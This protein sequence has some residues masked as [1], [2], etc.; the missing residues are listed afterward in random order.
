LE[1]TA[2]NK[3]GLL[4]EKSLHRSLKQWYARK[5]D[6]LEVTVEQWVIDIVRDDTLIEVQTRN[7]SALKKKMRQLTWRL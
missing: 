3:I 2:P 7:F 1:S 6:A 4:K 5:G